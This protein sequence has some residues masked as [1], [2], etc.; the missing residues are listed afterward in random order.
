MVE[1]I[2][3]TCIKHENSGNMQRALFCFVYLAI[4]NSYGK[5][6]VRVISSEKPL[7]DGEIIDYLKERYGITECKLIQI[8]SI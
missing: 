4:F 8:I 1:R 3:K 7:N 6:F 5:E 2:C